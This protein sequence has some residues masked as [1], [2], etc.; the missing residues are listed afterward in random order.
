MVLLHLSYA[1]PTGFQ[2]SI[3][4]FSSVFL[5]WYN[6]NHM[7]AQVCTKEENHKDTNKIIWYKITTQNM[8]Y[9]CKSLV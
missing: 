4:P 8:G 3:Y 9:T 7:I 5:H 6:S 2:Q 1:D